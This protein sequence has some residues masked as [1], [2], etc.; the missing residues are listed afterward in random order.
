MEISDNLLPVIVR[1]LRN[2]ATRDR[3]EA[4]SRALQGLHNL[5]QRE[6]LRDQAKA[7]DWIA[8]FIIDADSSKVQNDR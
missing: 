1:A 7:S 2:Q 6:S 8:Q 3:N 5:S 4:R